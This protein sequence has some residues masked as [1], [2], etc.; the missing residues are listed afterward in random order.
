MTVAATSGAGAYI[1]YTATATDA[2][3]GSVAASCW[4]RSG[5]R[6]FV[7]DTRV[8]CRAWDSARNHARASFTVTVT[9]FAPAT[10]PGTVVLSEGFEG[11]LSRWV[12]SGEPDWRAGSHEEYYNPDGTRVGTTANSV[13]TADDCDTGC[14][15]TL[16]RALDLSGR[17]G[18]TLTF[19]RFVD[20][21]IDS[22]EY[23]RVQVHKGGS[24]STIYSWGGGSGDDDM[25]HHESYSLSSYLVRDFKVRFV[26]KMSSSGE[27]AAVDNVEVRATGGASADTTAPVITV[28][29]AISRASASP[30]T[31]T[32]TPMPTAHDAVDGSIT[33]TCAPASGSAFAVGTTTVRCT[34]TDS[35]G[36]T[37]RAS[38]TVTV[39]SPDTAAPVVTVPAD[40][41]LAATSSSGATATFSATAH[42]AV[43]GSITP[44][45]APA[46][47]S[48]FAV[49]STT[50]RCTATDRA[51]NTG[52]ASFTVT[53]A[54]TKP[55][56]LTTPA[57]I[58]HK[59]SSLSGLK[60]HFTASAHD[61]VDGTI[62]PECTPDTG[63]TFPVGVTTVN[64]TATDR[65]GNSSNGKFDV[66]ITATV[67]DDRFEHGLS[68]WGQA[69]D[70]N[71]RAHAPDAGSPPNHSASNKVLE[72]DNCPDHCIL[73][74]E[75]PIDLSGHAGATLE[76]WRYVE[77]TLD[78]GEYLQVEAHSS[79]SW[80]ILYDWTHLS[81]GLGEWKFV[82]IDLPNYL[83]NDFKLRFV[84]KMD[85]TDED[86]AIDDVR[87]RGVARV[88][89]VTK[90]VITAPA[91]ILV[92]AEAATSSDAV[93][94]YTVH[95]HDAVD[96]DITPVCTKAGGS[97]FSVGVTTVRC[98]ATDAAGNQAEVNLSITVSRPALAPTN[99]PSTTLLRGGMPITATFASTTDSS[100]ITSIGGTSGLVVT[101][102]NNRPAVI[103]SSHIVDKLIQG[104]QFDRVTLSN[105]V[106][107]N[108]L[109]GSAVLASSN[110]ATNSS[111]SSDAALVHVTGS[112]ISPSVGT[113][114]KGLR[115]LTVTNYGDSHV[116]EEATIEI[117]GR[118]TN[119]VGTVLYDNVTTKSPVRGHDQRVKTGQVAA[120]YWAIRGDS[121]APIIHVGSGNQ[122][123]FLGVHVGEARTVF[124]E[125][126]G[127]AVAQGGVS[128]NQLPLDERRNRLFSI[129]SPWEN[130]QS[131]LRIPCPVPSC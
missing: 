126:S 102:T 104:K 106:G 51:G 112:T 30:V 89:D 5:D 92:V 7:G 85:G 77:D 114:Q 11:G 20:R 26:A 37:G 43:D 14:T 27:E 128:A 13:A 129:F 107:A 115:T 76:F 12:E 28:P 84:A 57:P 97:R 79:H 31:V 46:S 54:D 98:T 88:A 1:T 3:D 101:H 111:V 50:V 81:D 56:T 83:S 49:G 53:V 23:L 29:S 39:A 52:S 73:T 91:S 108:Q 90:P 21:S 22:G 47:G 36:N 119:S 62:T 40:M 116:P 15:L 103:V 25:W 60:V 45:C 9:P 2:V 68:Q 109:I 8:T 16:A 69:G 121:G 44:T 33:P 17:T 120:S 100:D 125:S 61:A 63:S 86:V 131:D 18:A 70:T 59:T 93:V 95:A 78:A 10:A 94:D 34:A 124:V 41:T 87:V 42:D 82:S 117:L 55:P 96:G 122:V 35:A 4:P 110:A 105:P 72:T 38:F 58:V 71:W 118:N 127:T 113:I 6:F 65:S 123:S 130:I 66:T 67:L 32:Y 74:L 75:Q 24:W 19:S 80:S 64:C 99:V 48:T